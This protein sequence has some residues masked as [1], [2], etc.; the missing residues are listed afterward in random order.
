MIRNYLKVAIRT[1]WKNRAFSFI[2]IS[3]LA[4]GIST[5]T[6]I[7]LYVLDELSY[8]RFH[9][10]GDRIFRLTELLHLPKEVRPQTVTSPPMAAAVKDNFAEVEKTVR[11]NRSSRTLSYKDN[12]FFDTQ[13]W[14]ADSTFLE[15][16]TFPV[17]RGNA[18]TA[19]VEPYSVV[20]TEKAATRYF[21]TED[22]LGKNMV[23]SDTL[24]LTVTAIVENVPANSHI[25]FDVV[26]SRTTINA[27][28]N[29]QPEDNWFNNGYYTYLLLPEGY[30]YKKLEAKF[31]AF[32]EKQMA[33]EKKESGLWYD[34]VLQPLPSIHLHSTT[35]YDMGPNG[36]IKYVYI[37]SIIAGLILLI[38]C[39]NYINL[40]TAKSVN[41]AKELGMRKV[42]GA[43]RNQLITQLMGESFLL[44][45]IAFLISLAIV[46]TALPAFN[47]LT[48]KTMSALVLLQPKVMLVTTGIFLLIGLLAGAY[49]ALTMSSFS[50]VKTLKSR[51][52]GKESNRLRQGLVVF[53]FTMSIILITATII[54]FRQIHFL[55]NQNLGLDKEQI[56]QV[57]IPRQL[58]SKHE[59]VKDELAKIQGVNAS[60]RTNFLYGNGIANIATLPE[61]ALE[62]EITSEAVISVDHDFLPTFKIDLVTGRNFSKDF[63]TDEAEAFIVN[64]SA[65]KHFNWGT[66]ET[67]IG[68]KINWGL[69]KKGKV[70]GVVKDFNY[71]SLHEAINPLIIHIEPDWFGNVAL[72]ITGNE[73]PETLTRI[74]SKMKE[75]DP[76]SP[77]EYSFMDEDFSNMYKAEQQT[78][79]IIG[80]LASLGIFIACLGLFGL[81]AFMAEQRTKEIGVRKV[82]G[83]EVSG[84]IALLSKDFLKLVMVAI[85]LAVPTA[86]FAANQWLDSF[87]YKTE[88]SWWIF[89]LAGSAA[90]FIAL[91][92]VSFQSVKAAIANPVDSLRNE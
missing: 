75:L 19:L 30:D 90:I 7:S 40:A 47:S 3:G 1:L 79:T 63:P 92:T 66:P 91:F 48:G 77:F 70:I 86:W 42:I 87:A 71:T 43:K 45:F 33:K 38:A 14:Y 78:Q 5:C 58:Q 32:L 34:F 12:K 74:E 28:N 62:N 31:P 16:F 35:P 65:V 24:T 9:E 51:L 25:Q 22:P 18:H 84:I 26:L 72:K 61:G 50:P 2:N 23:L 37:F 81:A 13:L 68:K 60:T 67:A 39:A 82:L 46:T 54:I 10:K 56:L 52:R 4:I 11:L 89:A 55:Q 73:I 20:L 29:N 83:A 27:V 53:Q 76:E 36:S 88:L 8:D 59:L 6:L 69:G 15:M 41:R 21:G 85:V 80:C 44:A 17:I 49:P 64:E 57:R